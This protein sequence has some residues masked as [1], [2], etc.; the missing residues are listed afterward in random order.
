MTRICDIRGLSHRTSIKNKQLHYTKTDKNFVV[1]RK[2]AR[3]YKV[4]EELN[5]ADVIIKLEQ[6]FGGGWMEE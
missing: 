3:Q 6:I 2:E 5:R 4:I 1:S